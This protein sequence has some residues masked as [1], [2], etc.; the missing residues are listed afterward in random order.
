[1]ACCFHESVVEKKFIEAKGMTGS[2]LPPAQAGPQAL[3]SS[4]QPTFTGLPLSGSILEM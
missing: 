3:L 2:A 1:M 4:D